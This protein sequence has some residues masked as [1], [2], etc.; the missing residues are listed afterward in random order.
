MHAN[1]YAVVDRI[2]KIHDMDQTYI[3]GLDQM[4]PKKRRKLFKD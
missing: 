4:F 3:N 2:S 1:T